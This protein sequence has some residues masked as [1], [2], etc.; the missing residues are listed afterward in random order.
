MWCDF[1]ITK[2]VD[3]HCFWA[4]IDNDTPNKIK[5]ISSNIEEHVS[6]NPIVPT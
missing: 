1:K 6:R 2:C 5:S 4:H 3:A